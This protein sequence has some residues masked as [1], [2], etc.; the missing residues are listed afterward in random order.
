MKSE[1][2]VLFS[3]VCGVLLIASIIGY[4]RTGART[5]KMPQTVQAVDV[6]EIP[7]IGRIEVQNGCGAEG[8]ADKVRDFLR[9]NQ[10]DVLRFGNASSFNFDSTTIVARKKEMTI[11]RTIAKIMRTRRVILLQNGDTTYDV[12][13]IIGRDYKERIQ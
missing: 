9:S 8:A 10:F 12:T 13:V 7:H 11:A 5:E 1:N 4:V 2:A 3:C 6:R